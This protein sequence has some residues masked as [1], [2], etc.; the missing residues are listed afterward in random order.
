MPKKVGVSL[1]FNAG[2]RR[3]SV[4]KEILQICRSRYL[5][6]QEI[7]DKLGMSVNTVR[8]YYLYPLIALGQ[9]ETLYPAKNTRKN[10]AYRAC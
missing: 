3:D 1:K 4:R 7:A 5:T 6:R 10:Q 9:I 8:A 2:T